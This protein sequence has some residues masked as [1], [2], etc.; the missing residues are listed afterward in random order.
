MK[1]IYYDVVVD[2]A[3]D[4]YLRLPL[5]INKNIWLKKKNELHMEERI[6]ELK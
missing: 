5:A 4:L 3:E 1:F 6:V 2:Q